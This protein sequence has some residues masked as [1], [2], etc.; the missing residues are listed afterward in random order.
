[1][2]IRSDI[3]YS[4]RDRSL[5]AV[6]TFARCAFDSSEGH[7]AI[8]PESAVEK[9]L[10]D[11]DPNV[12]AGMESIKHVTPAIDVFD[13][14][15][16]RVEPTFWPRVNEP[17]RIAAILEAAIVEIVF[18]NM[19]SVRIAT[20]GAVMVVRNTPMS[21]TPAISTVRQ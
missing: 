7:P 5:I 20:I 6:G 13:V 2:Q 9:E 8:S 15:I 1:M 19:E 4:I 11:I 12:N 18:I 21:A 3:S 14:N 10:K 17:K 16:I